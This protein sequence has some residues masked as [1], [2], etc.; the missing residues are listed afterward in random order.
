[1]I[2]LSAAVG[3]WA[4]NRGRSGWGWFCLSLLFSPVLMFI[5][6]AVSK[7]LAV[8]AAAAAV[9]QSP[10]AVPLPSASDVA[11]A[12]PSALHP[13]LSTANSSR[14]TPTDEDFAAALDECASDQRRTG[15][16]AK[17]FTEAMGDDAKAKALYA[18]RRAREIAQVRADEELDLF[19]RTE[20]GR[21][22]L[23]R[24][25][26]AAK[27]KGTCP[28]CQRVQPLDSEKCPDAKCGAT[29]TATGGWRVMPL[30]T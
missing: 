15:V 7:N 4:S 1:M 16:W 8:E 11:G 30:A 24:E 29:F 6:L 9:P 22:R 14:A 21:L 26:E 18:A 25:A 2:P 23:E 20:E 17:A 10:A 28:N 27:P 5:F 19:R 3:V 13:P 12:Q